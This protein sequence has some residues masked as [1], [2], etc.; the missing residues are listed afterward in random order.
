MT[1]SKVEL[2]G[3][4]GLVLDLGCRQKGGSYWV[5][6]DRWQKI[7]QFK[8]NKHNLSYLGDFCDEFLVHGVDVEGLK[9]GVDAELVELLGNFCEI[10]VTYAGG[11]ANMKDLQL[12]Q[13]AG[14]GVVSVTV[15]SALDIFG[16]ELPYSDVISWH[17]NLINQQQ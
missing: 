4:K 3:K 14:K 13:S 11:V 2:F 16:G 7:T 17:N 5:V 10:P 9:L 15:G 6:T 1:Q 8:D 12:V